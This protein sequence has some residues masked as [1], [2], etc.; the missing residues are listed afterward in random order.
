[1]LGAEEAFSFVFDSS[2]FGD[3]KSFWDICLTS[4]FFLNV[5]FGNEEETDGSFKGE[6]AGRSRILSLS[7]DG[8]PK[9]SSSVLSSLHPSWGFSP[10]TGMARAVCNVL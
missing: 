7:N 4:S 1:M 9:N 5:T 3:T 10:L 8:L 6:L 2:F